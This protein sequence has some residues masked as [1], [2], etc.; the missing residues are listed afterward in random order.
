MAFDALNLTPGAAGTRATATY[1]AL[2]A[3]LTATMMTTTATASAQEAGSTPDQIEW[4]LSEI[5]PSF[6]AWETTRGQL[7]TQVDALAAYR[8]RLGESA[9]TLRE[10][11]DAI[12]GAEKELSRLYVFAFLKADEDRRVSEDQ[13]RRGLAAALLSEFGEAV[14]FLSP[15][16]LS[17]G[18]A[19]IERYLAE[20][21][22]LARHAFNIRN[23]LRQAPHTLSDESEQVIAATGPVVQGAERIYAMLTSSDLPFPTVTLSSGDEITLDQAAYSLH[24]A[25]SN[26][27]DRKLVFDTF[28]GAWK[29]YETSIGQTLD[30]QVKAHVFQAK[31]RH[32]DSALDAA[33]SGP[34]I[35]T[36]VYH[37]LVEAAHRHLP[38]LHRYFKIRQ[39]ML[40]LDDLHYYDIYPSLVASD[41]TFDID[42]SK[43]LTLAS[44]APL[45]A[46][47]LDLLR[48]GFSGDWMHVYPQTGKAPGAY[49]YGSVYDLHPFLLLNHNGQF[50]DVSTFTH[51]WGHAI[52]TMLSTEHNP[53]ETS[54]Y[55]TFT[56]EIASTTNEVLLQEYMLA[57]DISD[58]ERLFYLGTALEAARGTFF[59]Q[60]MF[61][62]FEL[63]IHEMVEAGEALSGQKMSQVYEGLLRQYHGAD[64]NVLTI[65]PAYA[66]EWA[67][68]PHFYRNFYVFQYATSIAGGTMFAERFLTGDEQARDDYL[69]VL[70]AGGSR[71]A[72]E[73]LQEYGIDLATDA[74]YDALIARMDRVMDQIEAILDRQG[75]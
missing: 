11:F 39:R 35:P 22:G 9:A 66:V 2:V 18:S 58:N 54:S 43:A 1:V 47:Y 6:E 67:F 70:S 75:N 69:A 34:N 49:M 13:E 53:Y 33:L 15:E 20:E 19:T 46:H 26:R 32:Y 37:K 41:R 17:V 74:P 50:N 65:D 4:D 52:H 38:S 45:G 63:K 55:A 21:P 12:S 48:D 28:W 23:I 29:G 8:G 40:G 16:L 31:V 57:Q 27:A 36:A 64:D 71:Y 5:Y 42:E 73:L 7:A 72:Y 3:I 61:A 30:T 62:E 44:A 68:I 60:V 51:E 10:A 14:A 24:R 59:R 56:A 25:S